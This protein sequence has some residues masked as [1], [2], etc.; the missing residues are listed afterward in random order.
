MKKYGVQD[1]PHLNLMFNNHDE[2]VPAYFRDTFFANI[3]TS[4]R[5]ESMNAVTK[6]WVGSHSS[7]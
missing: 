2:W 1:N 5:S 7:L 3:T 4:Q 6:I